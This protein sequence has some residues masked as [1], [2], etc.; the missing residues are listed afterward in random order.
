MA[1]AGRAVPRQVLEE[2]LGNL[3]LVLDRCLVDGDEVVIMGHWR[4]VEAPAEL[5][6]VEMVEHVATI[7]L[8]DPA[9]RR[10]FEV[11]AIPGLTVP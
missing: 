1:A 10:Q 3:G 6:P 7:D 9:Q 5:A 11:G 2:L 4:P 8:F